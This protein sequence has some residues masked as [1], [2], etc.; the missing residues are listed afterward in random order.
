M[1]VGLAHAAIG[2]TSRFPEESVRLVLDP[3]KDYQQIP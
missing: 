3:T 2:V 1:S